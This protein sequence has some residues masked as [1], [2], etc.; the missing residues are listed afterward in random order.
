MQ[1]VIGNKNYSSW[2]LRPWLLLS[3]YGLPFEE[4][5]IAL[6]SE[7]YK[8]VLAKYSPS[9]RVPVLID[10]DTTI[11]DSLAICEYVSDR[12]LE[13]K[14]LPQ[15]VQA[16]GLC[17]AYCA[18]MHSGFT[19]IRSEMPMN[20]R[21]SRRLEISVTASAECRRIDQLFAKARARFAQSGD[22]LFGDFSLA[23]CFYAPIVLRFSTYGIELSQ[24]SQEY[25]DFL[26][27][28]ASLKAWV[29]AAK[30]EPE[31]LQDFEKGEQISP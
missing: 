30:K 15:D 8:D 21:A 17:R 23:D 4:V 18:E 22:Y 3:H 20:C 28:N 14:A 5:A 26:L 12:Y 29:E 7:G 11:W 16:R 24:T 31:L 10:G 6:F 25:A 27:E 19:T 13:G 9:L 1:L 2:S